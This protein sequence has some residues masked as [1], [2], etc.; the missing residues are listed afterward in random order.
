[1][2]VDE[3]IGLLAALRSLA[4]DI[5]TDWTFGRPTKSL[6]DGFESD[7][8]EIFDTAAESVIY[9]SLEGQFGPLLRMIIAFNVRS[10]FTVP[11][12]TIPASLDSVDQ[13]TG[14]ATGTE[15]TSRSCECG[16]DVP[17]TAPSLINLKLC[18]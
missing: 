18:L 7:L 1:M 13:P 5:V 11:T 4:L 3:Y 15:Q 17:P 8:F 10:I 2:E 14:A 12:H 16:F 6:Q 9:V